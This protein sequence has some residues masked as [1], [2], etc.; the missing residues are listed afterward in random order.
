MKTPTRDVVVDLWPLYVSG[1]A[2]ADTRA[3]VEEF[4]EREPELGEQ[5]RGAVAADL[6]PPA[7]AL[8][9][10]HERATLLRTQRRRA[11]QSMIANSLALLVSAAMT[12]V[13][14]WSLV[15]R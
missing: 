4:L 6:A 15:P 3:L 7:L 11:R 14:V 9:A 13:F 8:P 5:L 10:D 2:S 1:E 12:A